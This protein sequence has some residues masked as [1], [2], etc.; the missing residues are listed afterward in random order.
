MSQDLLA[1]TQYAVNKQ[2]KNLTSLLIKGKKKK[3]VKL[4]DLNEDTVSV[5]VK[6]ATR[7]V[8]IVR[9]RKDVNDLKANFTDA[10]IDNKYSE[11]SAAHL[12]YPKHGWLEMCQAQMYQAQMWW[13][14]A[15]FDQCNCRKGVSDVITQAI[16]RQNEKDIPWFMMTTAKSMALVI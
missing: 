1:N 11:E 13:F 9:R 7:V 14:R 16:L 8:V 5:D 6:I 12:C 15:L 4:N 2:E 3:G 10:V